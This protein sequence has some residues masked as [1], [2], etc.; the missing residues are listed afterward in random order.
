MRTHTQATCE[1][2]EVCQAFSF[3]CLKLV[4]SSEQEQEA[5]WK[6]S[7]NCRALPRGI[8]KKKKKKK[9][10][11]QTRDWQ[12]SS[13]KCVERSKQQ[14]AMLLSV[15]NMCIYIYICIYVSRER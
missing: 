1:M 14:P 2:I 4:S 15:E 13:H 12:S 6:Q 5:R 11:R 7:R 8:E 9:K 10:R 3:L